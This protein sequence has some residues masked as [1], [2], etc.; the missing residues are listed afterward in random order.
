M[1]AVM[2]KNLDLCSICESW[3]FSQN[4]PT[5]AI[6]KS[7]GYKIEHDF[8]A[9]K[10][11]G[12]TAIIYK[13]CYSINK[14]LIPTD[15]STFEFT[16]ATVKSQV[17]K[18]IIFVTLYRTGSINKSFFQE[19]D[20]LLSHI[21]SQSDNVV[22]SGDFNLH[23]E[24]DSDKNV[25]RC[26]DL[27]AS[28]G[29]SKYIN[30]PTHINNGTLDQL[31][32]FSLDRQLSLTLEVDSIHNFGSDHFPIYCKVNLAIEKKYFK[33]VTYR[34]LSDI[35][36][37]KLK[38]DLTEVCSTVTLVD[39]SVFGQVYESLKSNFK[40]IMDEHAPL[41][42]KNISVMDEAPWF[43][44]EYRELRSKRRYA[45]KVWKKSNE[46]LHYMKYK[47]LCSEATFLANSKKK[48]YFSK[49]VVTSK[50]NP[51]TLFKLVNNA[52]DRKQQQ[53]LPD[54]TK[55][56]EIQAKEFNDFFSEKIKKI[57]DNMAH[58]F[59]PPFIQF[60]GTTLSEFIPTSHDEIMSIIK[61]VSIKTS[62]DDILP[63]RTF[64]ENIEVLVPLIVQLTNLSLQNGSIDGLK[65]ADIA[66]MLKGTTLDHNLLKN[67]R[68]VS[69]LQFIGKVI[70]RVVL[71][72]LNDHLKSN[73]L[74]IPE[75]SAYAV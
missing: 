75:Q 35:D 28:Y 43:D 63:T 15:I 4:N 41:V 54:S 71:K 61:Q 23:F 12:G 26:L 57:R 2:D 19:L 27:F 68:P 32:A 31:F 65:S 40:E 33:Q 34:K 44:K 47:D 50:N 51:K 55:S 22:I 3:L 8:R 20:S 14:V 42:T 25:K 7:H 73:N 1:Q 9:N 59:S 5:T 64:I 69:N 58:E 6:I 18:K 21:C 62:P 30:E 66:P 72:R 48:A 37:D 39:D 74:E 56:I 67:F 13:A 29:F 16:C 70:E 11:G 36:Q 38:F 52:L 49:L 24:N 10:R 53:P 17:S 46:P 45:E 60:K